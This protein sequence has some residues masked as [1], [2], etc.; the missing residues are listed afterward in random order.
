[1]SMVLRQCTSLSRLSP[2]PLKRQRGVVLF[3][4]LI[5]LV[6]MSLA[7]IAL[8]RSVDSNVLLAGNLAFKQAATLA[9]DAGIETARTWIVANMTGNTLHSDDSGAGYYAAFSMNFDPQAFDW[10]SDAKTLLQ[11]SAGNV[12]SYV[13]HRMCT[14]PGDPSGLN[15]VKAGDM[16]KTSSSYGGV[17]YSGYALGLG[18]TTPVYR[19]TVRV[20]G[21]KNTASYVQAVVVL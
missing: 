4:A 5:V 6:V 3:I 17:S 9:A 20:Q 19:I 1:M 11:D 13:V 14:F 12:T 10:D 18:G 7:G 15:C 2:S 21:P 8:V 16:G